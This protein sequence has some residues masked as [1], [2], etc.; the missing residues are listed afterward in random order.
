MDSETALEKKTVELVEGIESGK[1]KPVSEEEEEAT[2]Y[3]VVIYRADPEMMEAMLSISEYYESAL[4]GEIS[5]SEAQA[6]IA[7]EFQSVV[8]RLR[9]DMVPTKSKKKEKKKNTRKTKT[10][11]KS[12]KSTSK[13]SKKKS[14][15]KKSK[16]KKSQS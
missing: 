3:G 4:R 5:P 2:V 1:V 15:T 7:K 13:T 9:E 14:T 16:S 12:S 11:K 8:E 10:T 6:R